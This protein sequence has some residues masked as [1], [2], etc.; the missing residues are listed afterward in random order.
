[1]KKSEALFGLVRIPLDILA[2]SAALLLSFRLR[3]ENIDL[4]PF[5]QILEPART[6]PPL[7]YYFTHFVVPSTGIF[8]TLSA[9]LQLY[10]LRSTMSAWSE[11]GRVVVAT[12]LLTAV[13]NAWFFLILKELFFSRIVLLHSIAFI[14]LF[15]CAVRASLILLQR[16]LL[17]SGVGRILV[18]SL[19]AHALAAH[20]RDTLREDMHY[21]YLGHLPDLDALKRI[22]FQRP[23]DL[24]LQTD[25]NPASEQTIALI[26]ECRSR[27]VGYAF[28]PQVLADVP[29]QLEVERLGLM[30]LIRFQP[31]PLDGWGRVGKRVFDLIVSALLLIILSPILLLIALVIFLTSG[32]PIFYVSTRIGEQGR[33][34]V[35]LLKFRTM[36]RNADA[37]KDELLCHNHRSD[38]P[39]FKMRNDPRVTR[40]GR[41]LRRWTLDELPQLFNVLIGQLSLVGPRP[42]LK[43]EV[44]KYSSRDRRVF[45][46]KPGMTGLAQVS[47]RSDLTFGD[48]VRLDQQ[49]IEDWSILLD[50]WVLWRTIFAVFGRKGAD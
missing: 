49:Y 1:M 43:Q 17:R 25:A 15:A 12:L 41:F 16:S 5:V 30:P 40:L 36:V 18:V 46:V 28:L 47:G 8:V 38:G 6:L 45:A 11:M 42:H 4:V 27:H 24:V 9:V 3:Q 34:Q 7:A 39:L 50:L 35:H 32:W 37:L 14:I 20:A 19:G 21:Y 26:D 48:E 2:V 44:E 29:H 10:T 22:L 31:T 33:K 23:I 13:I